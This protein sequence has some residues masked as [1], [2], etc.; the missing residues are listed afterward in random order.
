MTMA[1]AM[2]GFYRGLVH[3]SLIM[4]AGPGVDAWLVQG[5]RDGPFDDESHV[6]N[7]LDRRAEGLFGVREARRF[8]TF[9]FPL[10]IAG[11]KVRNSIFALDFPKDKGE[12]MPLVAG[13][14][15]ESSH[16]EM[17]VDKSTGLAL[18]ES[19]RI[20]RDD[21]LVVGVTRGEVDMA[22]DGM[23]FVSLL[24]AQSIFDLA[25][26]E[27]ILL[28]RASSGGQTAAA[29]VSSDSKP[30]MAVIL[31]LEPGIPVDL[32]REK[33][34]SWGDVTLITRAEQIELVIQGRL[35]RLRLQILLF[36]A[37]MYAVSGT[38]VSLTIFTIVL[39]KL[40]AISLLKLI[41]ATDTFISVW[42]LQYGLL[43]G[44]ISYGLSVAISLVTFGY[45]P[46]AVFLQPWDAVI[47]GLAL[48]AVCAFACTFSIRKA[49][50]VRAR[51]VLS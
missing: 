48:M 39:E 17:I 34:A 35:R 10:T 41:G 18:G 19:V 23:I 33:V 37:L 15:L 43:L 44:S 4:A 28:A 11:R 1:L 30:V 24:D 22:G 29:P 12:R 32:I 21:Y 36:V 27:A 8:L 49:L 42:I 31:T 13:H 40:Q 3:E 46:R 9:S 26:S 7:L 6:S 16:F 14:Y 25:P 47:A 51:E 2:N 50:S 38:I 45:F 20:G 5:G